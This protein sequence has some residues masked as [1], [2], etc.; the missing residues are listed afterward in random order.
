MAVLRFDKVSKSFGTLPVLKELSFE[1]EEGSVF[2]FIGKNGA[3]KTT[4]MKL[5]L[6]FLP[7]DGGEITLM[8]NKVN[9]GGTKI[10]KSVGYLPDVPE[11]YGYMTPKEYLRLCGNIAGMD[12]SNIEKKIAELLSLTGLE[13]ADRRI[14]GFSRGMKQRLGL[15][16]ALLSSPKLL[17]C[18]EPTSALDPA[19]RKEMLSILARIKH[20]TTIIFSTHILSDVERICDRIGVLDGGKLTLSGSLSAVKDTYRKD[21]VKLSFDTPKSAAGFGEL[22]K[23]FPNASNIALSEQEVTL[24]LLDYKKTGN[25][26]LKLAAESGFPVQKFELLEPTLE[27]VFLEVTK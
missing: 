16:Q 8:S 22:L 10:N 6:G 1:V 26:L 19:G 2:G 25:S 24:S 20:Q 27:D 15:S 11:F 21:S 7:L 12:K 13:K 23:H 4:A 5:A 17:I 14:Q 9:Y 18:D 3:G